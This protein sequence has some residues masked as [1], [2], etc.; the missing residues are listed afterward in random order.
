MRSSKLLSRVTER[1]S[2]LFGAGTR[3]MLAH[4]TFLFR[5]RRRAAHHLLLVVVHWN[6]RRPWSPW[7]RTVQASSYMVERTHR[8]IR[9]ASRIPRLV[10][11][12]GYSVLSVLPILAIEPVSCDPRKCE[13]A[14]CAPLA[15]GSDHCLRISGIPNL[16]RTNRAI[17]NKPGKSACNPFVCPGSWNL[18]RLR[19]RDALL[20]QGFGTARTGRI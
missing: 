18:F 20:F 9:F 7:R 10:G 2:G 17:R 19:D 14:S 15:S 8:D 6:S 11:V 16:A 3:Q 1:S 5:L 13:T 4:C 12:R